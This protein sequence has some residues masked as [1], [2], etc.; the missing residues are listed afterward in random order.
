MAKSKK[1]R[2]VAD[3][4][5][6]RKEA[7][8]QRNA[9]EAR[10]SIGCT[11]C[12]ASDGRALLEA[13]Q[14]EVA[15]RGLQEK[16]LVR[17]SGCHGFCAK[18]PLVVFVPHRICYLKVK[19]SDVPE[20]IEETA[21]KNNV[22][23]RLVYRDPKTGQKCQLES[24]IPFYK[25]QLRL[26]MDYN[27]RLDPRDIGS[28]FAIDGYEGLI[29]ALTRMEPEDVILEVKNSGLRG[30]GGAGFP[31]GF[32][33]E[34]CRKAKGSSKF[35]ICN[36]DEGDPGAYMDRSVMESNPHSVLEGLII[37]AYAI[38]ADEGYVY[39]RNEYPIAVEHIKL[40]IAQAYEAGLLGKD[41]LGT[42]FSFDVHVE[43]GAGAFVCGEETALIASIE[44]RRGEPRQR[45]PFPATKG[46][47]N[48]P[49]NINNVETLANIPLILTR[50]GSWYSHFGTRN[51]KGTKIFSLVGKVRNTGLVEVAMG[52]TFREIIYDIGGGI[53]DDRPFKAVQTGG[54]SGGCVPAEHLDQ[55]IDYESLS[56]LGTIMGSGGMI[57]MDDRTCMVDVAR[58]FM[59]FLRNESCG[60]CLTCREGTQRLWEILDD[61]CEGR[62]KPGHLPLMEDL[63]H[64][65]KDASLCGLGQT[66]GNPVLSTLRYF[67]DEYEEHISEKRCRA[68]VCKPLIEYRVV[69]EKCV[70]CLLCKKACPQDAITG[71]L[72]QAHV[73]D[74]ERCIKCGLC[75][76]ACKSD[77]VEHVKSRD[78]CHA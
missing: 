47:Y 17:L 14:A 4:D 54:P 42:G 43:R 62:G 10:I 71:E 20:I 8:A 2:S 15:R 37:G 60:K 28:Y 32:K 49:T 1:L 44:G 35:I 34:F 30:R 16:V 18:G 65:V 52:S 55:A 7:S 59:S 63:A 33:W 27:K 12:S 26:I 45:P 39:I 72:K 40:A 58:Y 77:A 41:I 29:K 50:G 9:Y 66:A 69:A 70:G 56:K 23:D 67:R 3:Y 24:Q 53:Q 19:P 22:I 61:I 5:R 31:T 13:F 21:L 64:C 78:L 73:I 25:R 75:Y 48:K 11:S 51:S 74:G 36:A 38:G 68:G 57:V 76:A 46:L 6:A